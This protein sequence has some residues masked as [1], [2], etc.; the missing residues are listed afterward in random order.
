MVLFTLK[1]FINMFNPPELQEALDKEKERVSNMTPAEKLAY[2][3]EVVARIDEA[4]HAL[5]EAHKQNKEPK[6]CVQA[7]CEVL[8]QIGQPRIIN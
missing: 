1:I 6:E 3:R 5:L 2:I 8:E 7:A 4:R